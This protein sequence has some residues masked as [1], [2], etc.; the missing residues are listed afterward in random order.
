MVWEWVSACG[1][2]ERVPQWGTPWLKRICKTRAYA[3]KDRL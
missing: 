3:T 1:E 2:V